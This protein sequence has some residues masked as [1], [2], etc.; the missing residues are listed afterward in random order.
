MVRSQS[1]LTEQYIIQLTLECDTKGHS[2]EDKKSDTGS[3]SDTDDMNSIN[4]T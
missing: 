2:S 1:K 4:C 3:N